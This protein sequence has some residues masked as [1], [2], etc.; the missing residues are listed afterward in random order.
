[1]AV[2][3]I[4]ETDTGGVIQLAERCTNNCE[5][6]M[7]V[8]HTKNPEARPLTAASLDSYPD[9]PPEPFSI[10]ITNNTVTEVA[11]LISGRAGP[12]GYGPSQYSTLATAF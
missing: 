1:M 9:R 3:W 2:R 8:L 5:R 12:G 10:D 11:G 6:V 4:T 7:E